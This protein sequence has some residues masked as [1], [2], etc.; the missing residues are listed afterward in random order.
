MASQRAHGG[1]GRV[2]GKLLW[3]PTTSLR[4]HAEPRRAGSVRE[5]VQRAA[6][7]SVLLGR[8][9]VGRMHEAVRGWDAEPHHRLPLVRGRRCRGRR[10]RWDQGDHDAHLQHRRVPDVRVGRIELD[11]VHPA[12]RQ[13]HEAPLGELH[14]DQLPDERHEAL[15]SRHRGAAL[16]LHGPGSGTNPQRH[17][18]HP[19]LRPTPRAARAGAV[20]DVQHW[21]SSGHLVA[22]W[23]SRWRGAD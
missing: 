4:A 2:P 9:A 7:P 20:R 11:G 19:R 13:R 22:R 15:H 6:V 5:A 12:L 17:V 21:R 23:R 14:P 10:V 8:T 18:Q 3:D 16:E 1:Q